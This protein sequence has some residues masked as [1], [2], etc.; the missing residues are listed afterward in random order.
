MDG[1]S[2][3]PYLIGKI[4]VVYIK[5]LVLSC[6]TGGGHNSAA[7]AVVEELIA[8]LDIN[9]Q[10]ILIMTGSMGFE[11]TLEIIDKLSQNIIH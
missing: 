3:P 2:H 7:K 9:K 6:G 10:Y 11:N 1:I 8:N 5:V 4:K